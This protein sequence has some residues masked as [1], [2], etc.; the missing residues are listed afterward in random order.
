MKVR[1]VHCFMEAL[2]DAALLVKPNGEIMAANRHAIESLKHPFGEKDITLHIIDLIPERFHSRHDA[3]MRGFVMSGQQRSMGAS[4]NYFPTRLADG[5]EIMTEISIGKLNVE[6]FR[7]PLLLVILIDRTDKVRLE[8]E[9]KKR[10]NI[11]ELTELYARTCFMEKLQH[12][13][14]RAIRYVRPLTIIYFDIDHFKNI[15]DS[16]GHYIGDLVLRQVGHVCRNTIRQFDF[17]G[18]IGGEEFVA[19]LPETSLE[20]AVMVAERLRKAVKTIHIPNQNDEITVSASFGVTMMLPNECQITDL[21][22]RGDQAL[23]RAKSNGR[24]RIEI[25]IPSTSL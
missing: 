17:T 19:V 21:L 24:D 18:R 8:E 3:L 15:N 7:E 9:L 10:A 14:D 6:N 22:K 13:A 5:T 16:Y 4:G 11:D 2:P 25:E 1:E 23:Y 20:A 12:E